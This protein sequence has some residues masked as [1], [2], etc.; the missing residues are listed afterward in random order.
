MIGEETIKVDGRG[1][2]M[3]SESSQKIRRIGTGLIMM[4]LPIVMA[5]GFGM[6]P[7]LLSFSIMTDAADMMSEFHNNFW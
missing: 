4:L 7:N 5:A 1:Y 3:N 6:H 2:P